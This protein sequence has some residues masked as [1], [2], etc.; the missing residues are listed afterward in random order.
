MLS[1]AVALF[2][3]GVVIILINPIVGLVPGVFLMILAL[4]VGVIGLLARRVGVFAGLG[5]K[6][7]CPECMAK[8]PAN[9]ALCRSCG[10][11]Y[12]S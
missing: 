2:V 1:V 8:I 7:R 11:H 9:A 5:P 12:E 10:H 6:K 3:V 4:V